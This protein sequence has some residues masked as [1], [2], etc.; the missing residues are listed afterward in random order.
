MLDIKFIRENQEAVK[1]ALADRKMQFDL[2]VL[3][4]LDNIR[5]KLIIDSEALRSRRNELGQMMQKDMGDD[6][7][8]ESKKLKEEL[9][10]LEEELAETEKEFTSLMMQIPNIPLEHLPVG[11]EEANKVIKEVGSIPKFGFTPK[12][13]VDLGQALDIIDVVRAAKVSGSRFAYL[14]NQGALLELALVN[15]AMKTLT[16][17][18]FAPVLP[19]MLIKQNI[20]EGLGYWQTGGDYYQVMD[21]ET[22]D[23]GVESKN[24]L[25][26]IGTGEHSVVPMHKDEM[27]KAADLPK[28]YAAF[29]SCFRREA[30]TYGKDTKG[31]LRVHQFDKVEMV[32]FVSKE[33]DEPVK[34]QMLDLAERM[35]QALELPYRVV[36][37]ATGD[38]SFPA[39]ETIDIETW[40]PSQDKYRETHSIST[41]SN[42]QSRRLNIR[43]Q[44][45][46]EKK[47]VHILN[48]TAIAIPRML[49]AILENNQQPD[50][51]VKIPKVLQEFT[52]FAEIKKHEQ[53][54]VD[55][56][57]PISAYA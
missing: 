22:D 28:K 21:M 48:G 32:A 4:D 37:L 19:P 15:Y 52:G 16:K 20:T 17:E 2:D 57:K 56:N 34:K 46:D 6:V 38:I 47:F 50:G 25:Y 33:D 24:P 40:I 54:N 12:D 53:P 55:R 41:T 9:S 29:S 39:A 14:K 23:K 44:A 42:F 7:V 49:V 10:D 11:G 8:A 43:Y 13:H 26:L 51:S 45:K 31:I 27:F 36:Q 3:I 35:M 30:G 1:K 18:G 5:R